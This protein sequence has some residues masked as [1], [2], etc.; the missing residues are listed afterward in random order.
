VTNPA[1]IDVEDLQSYRL[2]NKGSFQGYS[3]GTVSAGSASVLE[4]ECDILIPAAL[5]RQIHYANAPNIKAKLI[6]EAA[7]GPVTPRADEILLKSGKVIIPDMLLNAGGVTG[8]RIFCLLVMQINPCCFFCSVSYFEWLKNL[9]HVRFGRIN[10]AW[11]ESSKDNMV[12]WVEEVSGKHMNA[13]TR[14]NFVRG[15]KVTTKQ[16]EKEN[17]NST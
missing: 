9:S 7:N 3:K 17:N 12:S 6:G 11:E 8:T 5:E 10:R 2:K 16:R 13:E 15:A 4:V 14:K 1:G